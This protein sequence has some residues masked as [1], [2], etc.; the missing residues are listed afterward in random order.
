MLPEKMSG[1][2]TFLL[3]KFRVSLLITLLFFFAGLWSYQ[4]IARENDPDVEIPIGVIQTFWSG[5]SAQDIENLITRKIEDEVKGLENLEKYTS[6]S[7][8]NIS[9]VSVEF[10]IG[11]DL[12]KNF[13]KLREAVSDAENNLPASLKNSPSITEVTT[14]GT[15]ILTLS[16]SGD[17]AFKTL[18]NYAEKIQED[19]EK[20]TGVK[21]AKISGLPEEKFHIYLDPFKTKGLK[22]SVEEISSQLQNAHRDIP[23]G[24]IFVSGQKMEIRAQG[25]FKTVEDLENFPVLSRGNQKVHLSEIAT[26]RREFD[27]M[28]T[29]NFISTGEPS[30]RYVSIDILKSKSKTN[31]LKVVDKVEKLLAKYET[32]E[33]LPKN[34]KVDVIF[35]G[36]DEIRK[37]LDTL[38]V[39]GGQTLLVIMIILLLFLGWR[40]SILVFIAVPLTLLSGILMLF[41]SGE[42]FNFL[43]LFA[44]VL[45]LGLLVDNA[46]I[47]IEGISEGIFEKKLNPHQSAELAISK[48]RY[49]ILTGTSTTIFAFLPMMIV[50]SGVSGEYM[51][52]L[53]K[54]ITYTLL[55]SLIISIF[56][57][58]AFG[59]K[60]FEIFPPKKLEEGKIMKQIK[61]FYVRWMQKILSQRKYV[62][63]VLVIS[64]GVMIFAFSLAITKQIPVEVFPE[65]DQ[66]YFTVKFELPPGTKKEETQKIIPIVEKAVLPFFDQKLLKNY[67]FTLGQVSPFSPDLRRSGGVI[68]NESN[69]LGMTINL[70]DKKDREK[71]SLQVSEM[72]T[73]SLEK[74]IPTFITTT[75]SQLKSGPPSGGS[76]VEVRFTGGDLEHLES[77][78]QDFKSG[79]EKIKLKKGSVL[80][81]F[82]D[83]MGDS[84]PQMNWI[85]DKEKLRH[86]GLSPSQIFS[87][88]RSAVEG[89]TILQI[90]DNTDDIDV[91][92][93]L[94]FGDEL[95]WENPNSLEVLSQVLLKTQNG[96]FITLKDIA[97][98]EIKNK[99]TVLR[100]RNGDRV[101]TVGA[102]I[103]GEATASE[104]TE[105]VKKVLENLE[106]NPEESYQ[107]GGD[108]EETGRLV[109]EMGLAMILAV[110]LILMILVLQFDSFLQAFVIVSLLPLSLTGVF[111]GFW[112]SQTP[113]SFPTMI[114]IVALA[115]IIV[116]DAIV[117][118]DQ[119][120]VKFK[121]FLSQNLEKIRL[122]NLKV[123]ESEEKIIF[124]KSQNQ[125]FVE[126]GKSRM[127]PIIITSVTTILGLIPLSLSDPIW[128]GLGFAIIY[129]MTLSTVLTLLLSPCLM[130]LFQDIW[131]GMVWV[132]TFQFLRK[133][134][135]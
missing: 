32:K 92:L 76:A 75:V 7:R 71:T 66:N 90:S 68:L 27:V 38:L 119:I 84:V 41:L 127:Q 26:V 100:R 35:D 135:N 82:T 40:E 15:P 16:L 46:I 20:I 106:L 61:D 67:F 121:L 64:F 58:P 111:L 65:A 108:N 30:L 22:L 60:F 114:G 19:L 123:S 47:I 102:E 53:P 94:Y 6:S 117:L 101:V 81:N 134:K 36:A 56:I 73:Q 55:A 13:Q 124:K 59:K 49:S 45:S 48:F 128:Q 103:L 14:S 25:E 96:D 2:W 23:V 11:T 109:K 120:N 133:N 52:I 113:I 24:E 125:A 17:F 118:L 107:V 89:I 99:R 31:I 112:I 115:G 78:V 91:D 98:P 70:V 93:R 42:T 21:E 51:S 116:N 130:I 5:A 39:S 83:N 34:L 50:I 79:L 110:F 86:F 57:L 63:S 37:S 88:L 9:I 1:F 28:D 122:K 80:H 131:A 8:A 10:E 43:S 85:F 104:F 129:G 62:Y 132:L 97:T 3:E 44:L 87:S 18:K 69:V 54:T 95:S 4:E 29:E 126:A 12:D 77:V 105:D 33:I 74:N 72:I